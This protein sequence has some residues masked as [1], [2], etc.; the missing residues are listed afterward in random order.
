[1]TAPARNHR[2]TVYLDT[3]TT[4]LHPDYRHVWEIGMVLDDGNA[5]PLRETRIFIAD[6][7]LADADE[8]SL[9][10]SGFYRR[11]PQYCTPEGLDH[12]LSTGESGLLTARDAAVVVE[13]WTRS[14][15][16]AG[17]VPS[18]DAEGLARM[19]RVH[20]LRPAWKYY[21][22]DVA[23][24]AE[25]WLNGRAS[26]GVPLPVPAPVTAEQISLACG[27][28]PP[29]PDERHTALGD[30]RWAMRLDRATAAPPQ[31]GHDWN[32]VGVRDELTHYEHRDPS[33]A[34]TET[35]PDAGDNTAVIAQHAVLEE[36]LR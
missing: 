13:R 19:L 4:H 33:C 5:G 12:P 9:E 34:T 17:I 29:G 14:A 32:R 15:I 8:R 3:E 35:E 1:M 21:L 30:A 26:L 25:G 23:T 31:C 18:F 24:H 22:R 11:H 16:V 20:R 27:I 28:Q 6:V 10:I 36:E 2:P 7:D